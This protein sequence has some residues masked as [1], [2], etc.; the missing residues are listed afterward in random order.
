[1]LNDPISH[2]MHVVQ[3]FNMV[4][5]GVKGH[6]ELF[7]KFIRL[8]FQIPNVS[9]NVQNFECPQR[10]FGIMNNHRYDSTFNKHAAM[11]IEAN[12]KRWTFDL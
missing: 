11:V 12:V 4:I 2:E 6:S 5:G 9:I 7:Q 3:Q 1:M 10:E 8:V